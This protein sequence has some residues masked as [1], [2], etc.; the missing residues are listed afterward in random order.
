MTRLMVVGDV[1]FSDR[2]PSIRTEDYTNDILAKV[3]FIVET[4]KALQ[5]DAIVQLGDLFHIKAPSRTSHALVQMVHKAMT[6]DN[7]LEWIVVPGNH[8][9][10]NDRIE[11]L[12]KQPLGTLGKMDG[13][14]ILMGPHETLP[15]FAIPYLHDWPALLPQWLRRYRKWEECVEGNTLLITHAPIFP[16]GEEPPYDYTAAEDWAELVE[17]GD[18]A[19]GHIHDP[20]GTYQVPEHPNV[21]FNNQGAVSR[22]S[23]HEKTLKRKPACTVWDSDTF[24]TLTGRFRRVEIPHR[25][26]EAVFRLAEKED[27]DARQERVGDFLAGVEQTTLNGLTVEEVIHHAEAMDLKPGTL[28]MIKDCIEHAMTS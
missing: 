26:A 27:V 4:A 14:T 9:V 11:S 28:S 15:I 5:C 16:P 23:L 17:H 22:G 6:L 21:W 25:P 12:G 13:V 7:D 1:H 8:D 3:L 18:V 2:P 19:Y 20:H 24:E 10:S